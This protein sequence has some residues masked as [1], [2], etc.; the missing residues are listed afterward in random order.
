VFEALEAALRAKHHFFY[1]PEYLK[2][3]GTNSITFHLISMGIVSANPAQSEYYA[4]SSDFDPELVPKGGGLVELGVMPRLVLDPSMNTRLTNESMR[5]GAVSYLRSLVPDGEG[6]TLWSYKS[7][8]DITIWEQLCSTDRAL[9]Q[10]DPENY[11]LAQGLDV[12]FADLANYQAY[13][14]ARKIPKRD[15][16]TMHNALIDARWHR[17]VFMHL[18][19]EHLRL[20]REAGEP[21]VNEA[22]AAAI[23]EE[24][25]TSR[26]P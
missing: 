4:I 22:E 21:V 3:V 2:Q 18:H 25:A 17:D 16:E 15:P 14:Q 20:Q 12:R 9:G 11:F 26:Q 10:V 5:K 19:E 8:N 7:Q 24:F 13:L 1:D 6:I 23:R